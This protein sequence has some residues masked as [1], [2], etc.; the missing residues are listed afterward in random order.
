MFLCEYNNI[1]YEGM[2]DKSNDLIIHHIKSLWK[3]RS[4]II[5]IGPGILFSFQMEI[6]VE[7]VFVGKINDPFCDKIPVMSYFLSFSEDNAKHE[8]LYN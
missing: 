4:N 6:I 2:L 3:T 7:K 1:Q 8:K 5:S